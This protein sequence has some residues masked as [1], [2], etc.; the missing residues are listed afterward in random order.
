MP[1][2][3]TKYE[4][5]WYPSCI[6]L[7]EAS[8]GKVQI[9][10]RIIQAG[11]KVSIIGMRQAFLRGLRPTKGLLSEPL[12]VHELVHKNH[13]IWMTDLPEELNQIEELLFTVEPVGSILVGGLG[14]GILSTEVAKLPEVEEV[15]VIEIDKNIIKLCENGIDCLVVN[16]D[17][18]EYLC[19]TEERY[20]YYLLD[21]WQSTNEGTWWSEVVPQR[22]IIRQRWD[23]RPIVHCWAEDI[24]QGQ[25]FQALTTKPPHWYTKHLPVPMSEKEARSFLRNVGLPTWERKYG[26]AIDKATQ[27]QE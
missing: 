4:P 5:A 9:R 11:E 25:I 20:D 10:H 27:E 21:T 17:I 23:K 16:A 7:P 12:L 22:R 6:D 19:T 2:T 14:L 8:S 3:N 18:T 13:G 26:K 1:R 24:M 15:T